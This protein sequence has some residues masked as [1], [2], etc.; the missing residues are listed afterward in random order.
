MFTGIT[1]FMINKEKS[2]KIVLCKE[3]KYV[4]KIESDYVTNLCGVVGE[5]FF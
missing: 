3:L 1:V 5:D 2:L 4:N